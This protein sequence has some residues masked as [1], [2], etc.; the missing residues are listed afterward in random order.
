MNLV[1]HVRDPFDVYIGRACYGYKASKWANPFR[2]RDDDPA[3]RYRVILDYKQHV[4]STPELWN[5]LPELEG[6]VLGCWCR[7]KFPCH[8]DALLELLE[9][10]RETNPAHSR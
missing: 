1:V 3:E 7:P 5:A 2:L 10:Y 8:G 6:K 9:E 4:R